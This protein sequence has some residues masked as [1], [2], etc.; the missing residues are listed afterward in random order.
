MTANYF[1][2]KFL[3]HFFQSITWSLSVCSTS[4]NCQ[5]NALQFGAENTLAKI[6]IIHVWER[7][8]PNSVTNYHRFLTISF[9][10]HSISATDLFS[11]WFKD[12]S[13]VIENYDAF[14]HTC[15]VTVCSRK[16]KSISPWKVILPS[17][18]YIKKCTQR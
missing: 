17:V 10:Y 9:I 8:K 15:T 7:K 16:K 5:K 3:E 2:R 13:P 1:P 4:K 18:F 12:F 14:N 6:A 11:I